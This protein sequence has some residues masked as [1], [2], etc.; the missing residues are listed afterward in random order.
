MIAIFDDLLKNKLDKQDEVFI[1]SN[2]GDTFRYLGGLQKRLSK[3]PEA[4]KNYDRS[5]EVYDSAISK[6]PK[7]IKTL[8]SKGLTLQELGNLCENL[9]RNEE[10][11]DLY[12]ESICVYDILLNKLDS[13]YKTQ[14]FK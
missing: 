7:D 4:R 9:E 6:S 8:N 2:Q 12:L 14:F 1:L 13:L 11:E 3:Y 10:A 5:I